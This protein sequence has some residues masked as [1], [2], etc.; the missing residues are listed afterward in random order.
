MLSEPTSQRS[1]SLEFAQLTASAVF[2]HLRGKFVTPWDRPF[3]VPGFSPQSMHFSH[4]SESGTLRG[5]HYTD[6]PFGQSKLVHCVRGRMFDVVVDMRANSPT[7]RSWNGFSLDADCG[8][9]IWIPAG[10]AHGFLTLEPETI[11]CYLISG[12]YHPNET[13]G[14]RWN[15]PAFSIQWPMTEPLVISQSDSNLADFNL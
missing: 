1:E 15:D 6:P 11:V 10:Y 5:L 2:S 9:S 13:R 8:K 7:F 12:K 4:N 3:D 14:I